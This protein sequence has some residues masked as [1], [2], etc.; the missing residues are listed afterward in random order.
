M[1]PMERCPGC[2]VAIAGSCTAWGGVPMAACSQVPGG[3]VPSGCGTQPPA[4]MS[5]SCGTSTTPRPASPAW[6]GVPMGR[7]FPAEPICMEC[8]CG[9]W[10]HA[11][12]VG[13]IV[14]MRP[15][16]VAWPGARMARGWSAGTKM[17]AYLCGTPLLQLAGHHGAIMSVAFQPRW[18]AVGH[19]LRH[20]R[21]RG[22][23]GVGRPERGARA[24]LCRA[25]GGG[26]CGDLGSERGVGDQWRQ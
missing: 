22:T 8:R 24:R 15:C 3:I 26:Y 16:S 7:G 23:G 13:Q 4:P 9:M 11:P 5:R 20:Q 14:H 18:Q 10:P 19:D 21:Q 2:C 1:W 25:S 12:C 17:A 6:P